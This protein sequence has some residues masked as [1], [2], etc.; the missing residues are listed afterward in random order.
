MR[1]SPW[2]LST[3]LAKSL[4][5]SLASI[6]RGQAIK[7]PQVKPISGKSHLFQKIAQNHATSGRLNFRHLL[8]L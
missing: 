7:H 3:A 8:L 6:K 1:P 5:M 2:P 4:A